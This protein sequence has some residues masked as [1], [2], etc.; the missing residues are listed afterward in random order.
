MR[1]VAHVRI[2][3]DGARAL[4]VDIRSE[5]PFAIRRSGTRILLVSSAAAPVGG[6]D[7]ALEI[8]V[9]PGAHADLGTVA[10]T[11]VWTSPT[12]ALSVMTTTIRAGAGA[13]VLWRPHPM[14]SV[15]GSDHLAG[16]TVHLAADARAVIVEEVALGRH[17]EPG[18]DLELRLRVERDGRPLMHHVERFGPGVAGAGSVVSVGSARHVVQAVLVGVDAGAP[19][20]VVEPDRAAAWLP[21]ADDAVVILATS[22]DRPSAIALLAAVAPEIE[23]AT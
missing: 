4:P 15:A 9:E 13:S 2:A 10:A 21:V 17:G 16:T 11:M 12:R 3:G 6:D 19:R 18:G 1:G 5:P 23:L 7:L 8:D 14:V 20:S 22:R